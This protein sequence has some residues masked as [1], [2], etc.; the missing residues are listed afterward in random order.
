M[1]S[2]GGCDITGTCWGVDTA[3]AGALTDAQLERMFATPLPIS[4]T[5]GTVPQ[6]IDFLWGYV[7]L[8]GNKPGW[9]MTG[10]RMRSIVDMQNGA[11]RYVRVLLVQHCR[12]GSS[13]LTQAQ[14][15]ADGQHAAEYAASQGYPTDCHLAVDD[16]SI[17]NPG[18]VAVASLTAW[19]AHWP[20]PLVYEG[21]A[22]GDGGQGVSN[23]DAYWGAVGGWAKDARGTRCKQYLQITHCGVGVD[24]DQAH[25]DAQ[26]GVLR[27]FGRLPEEESPDSSGAHPAAT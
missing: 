25:P 20:S 24:P 1:T 14:G 8:P 2:Y 10:P 11:G 7:P 9:D 23:C 6:Y 26:G 15:D 22:P 5:G 12:S 3:M 18:P 13:I 4:V 21:F 16:E 17:R 19:C 27:A